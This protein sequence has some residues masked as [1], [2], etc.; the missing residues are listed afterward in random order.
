MNANVDLTP[1]V[2]KASIAQAPAPSVGSAPLP[3][4]S[5]GVPSTS[6]NA[7]A[8]PAKTKATKTAAKEAKDSAEPGEPKKP[9]AP[10]ADYGYAANAVIR[11]QATD[12]NYRGHT[13]EWYN[14]LK[15]ADGKTAEEFLK[16]NEGVTTPKG[17][18]DPPRGWLRHFVQSGVVKL[19][20]PQ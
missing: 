8:K 2:K 20:K 4:A 12:K 15:A 7:P 1:P 6:A 9:R 3:E 11:V 18:D 10:R 19:E 5:E 16:A 14:R 13:L 17:A